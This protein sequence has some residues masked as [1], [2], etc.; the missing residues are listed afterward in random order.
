ME[1]ID[2]QVGTQYLHNRYSLH[3]L[4]TVPSARLA[5]TRECWSPVFQQDATFADYFDHVCRQIMYI[6]RQLFFMTKIIRK[7]GI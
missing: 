4:Y 2:K 7:N 1:W 6:C 5:E 3:N